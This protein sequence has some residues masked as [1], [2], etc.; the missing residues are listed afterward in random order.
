MPLTFGATR[1]V[2]VL[3]VDDHPVVRAGYRRL[4]DNTPDIRV[5]AEAS[6]GEEGCVRY[7]DYK[8]DVVVVDLTM[9]GIGGL[10]TIRRILAKNPA[11]HILVFSIHDSP[12]LVRRALEAGASGYLTKSS[13]ATRM[14]EAIRQVVQGKSYLDPELVPEIVRGHALESDP[15]QSLSQREFQIFQMLAEG[16]TVLEIAEAL[17]ISAKTV[18]VHQTKIMKK[19]NI[20][21]AA[22]L[23]RLAIRYGVIK[24]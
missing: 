4:L 16:R 20:G 15:L 24:P 1:P 23:A 22:Q 19:L 2:T 18:G 7:T 5:V 10:E 17:S 6:D 13:A 8:P 3:L 12:A 11:A 14:V 9:P 21:N